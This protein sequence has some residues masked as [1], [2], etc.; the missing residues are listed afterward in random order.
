M[1][2]KYHSDHSTL[3]VIVPNSDSLGLPRFLT[4]M[5]VFSTFFVCLSNDNFRR[6]RPKIDK[7]CPMASIFSLKGQTALITGGTR[8]IGQAMA[9]ALAEAGADIILVQV[10]GRERAL[11]DKTT[12]RENREILPIR[13]QRQRLSN[14][15]ERRQSSRQT[16]LPMRQS[17]PLCHR[18]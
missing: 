6:E 18:L 9:Y 17:R 8:G 1:R 2:R 13:K 4:S 15:G 3:E 16:Y 10:I 11:T 5:K 14:W 12:K 7:F